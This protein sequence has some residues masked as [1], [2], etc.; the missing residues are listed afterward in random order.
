VELNRVIYFYRFNPT[1]ITSSPGTL[2]KGYKAFV[3]MCEKYTT[4]NPH[5]LSYDELSTWKNS[6]AHN[7][8]SCLVRVPERKYVT[9]QLSYLKEK[10]LYPYPSNKAIW[11]N[12][13]ITL[14]GIVLY[15]LNKTLI[16]NC[17]NIGY[18][19]KNKFNH[20]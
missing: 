19:V 17:L 13:R 1:S 6:M 11:G 9:E 20:K 18:C 15:L 12:N 14:K 3:K 16:F 10:G 7:I 5:S 2:K 4:I 8:I